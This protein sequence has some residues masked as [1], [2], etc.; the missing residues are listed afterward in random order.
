VKT[1]LEL[2]RETRVLDLGPLPAPRLAPTATV[3]QALQMMVRA[4]RGAVIV[5]EGQKPVGIFTERDLV[6]GPIEELT[7][8]SHRSRTLLRNVMSTPL[9][10]VRRQANLDEVIETMAVK[11]YRHL[12]VVD[13]HGDLRGL[14]Y[15][16]DLVQFV[17]DQFPEETVNLPP[18]LRQQ[19]Q[20]PEGA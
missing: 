14:L 4:R 12:V 8:R 16:T 17:I 5:V 9:E 20:S 10:T 18:R 13:R 7:S 11:G 15:T 3:Q 19:Y 1:L 2:A 6:V